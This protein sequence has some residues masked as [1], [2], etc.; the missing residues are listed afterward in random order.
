LGHGLLRFNCFFGVDY[1]HF[2]LLAS[3]HVVGSWLG[4]IFCAGFRIDCVKI[5]AIR[6]GCF[7][8]DQLQR[9]LF[10]SIRVVVLG[11]VR[12]HR[13]GFWIRSNKFDL[14]QSSCH[15][16][17]Q[18]ETTLVDFIVPGFFGLDLI[19]L[20]SVRSNRASVCWLH[21]VASLL[22]IS[23]WFDRVLYRLA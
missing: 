9:V 6:F 17:H 22:L 5:Y 16:L 8:L 1:F 15:G 13:S 23:V 19:T 11:L 21:H 2:V 14:I 7:S 12:F 10:A 18:F 4:S 20:G 3:V